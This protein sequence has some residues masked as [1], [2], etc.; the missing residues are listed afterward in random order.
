[1]KTSRLFYT[2]FGL[3]GLLAK[4][5]F[6]RARRKYRTTVVSL[7]M[8][9][10]LFISSSVFC[11]YLKESVQVSLYTA[12]Y[13][14]GYMGL[15]TD[16]DIDGL[17]ASLGV[18]PGVQAIACS[19]NAHRDAKFTKEDLDTSYQVYLDDVAKN[20]RELDQEAVLYSLDKHSYETM[21]RE[22]GLEE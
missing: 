7:V 12:N 13:D 10:V 21:I 17:V 20:G 14:V 22:N 4:K 2:L 5:Y 16:T 18:Q 8:S 3:E 1:M 15:D 9:V 11:M 6:K 19:T